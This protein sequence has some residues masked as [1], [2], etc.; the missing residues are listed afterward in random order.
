MKRDLN[1]IKHNLDLEQILQKYGY[2]FVPSKSSAKSRVYRKGEQRLSVIVDASFSAKYFTDLNDPYF[3][4]DIF[5]FLER[6]EQGNYRR[7]FEVI[8]GILRPQSA[9][10]KKELI[11]KS[12]NSAS[13]SK[14]PTVVID[15]ILREKEL[16]RI[17]RITPLTDTVYAEGRAITKEVL[18]SKEFIGRIQNVKAAVVNS[19]YLNTGFPMYDREG[20]M[21][22]IDLRNIGYKAFP[23]GERGEALWHSNYFFSTYRSLKIENGADIPTGTIGTVYQS[24]A[25]SFVFTY[26]ELGKETRVNLSSEQIGKVFYKVPVHRII[27]S[28][29]AIDAI[30]LKQLSPEWGGERRLYVATCGQPGVK[31]MAFLQDLLIQNPRA[32]LVIAQDGDSAG[33]RFAINYLALEHPCEHPEKKIIPHLTYDA[34]GYQQSEKSDVI[35]SYKISLVLRYPL[36]SGVRKA[37]SANEEFVRELIYKMK[38]INNRAVL[39]EQSLETRLDENMK[40]LNTCFSVYLSSDTKL[41][42]WVLCQLTE[43]IEKRQQ[44]KLFHCVIPTQEL[45]DFNNVLKERKGQPLFLSDSMFLLEPPLIVFQ[46]EISKVFTMLSSDFLSGGNTVNF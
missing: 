36:A 32:Q 9:L 42:A 30:S 5:T 46:S 21:V 44:Q 40:Y 20:N 28:E 16:Y 8:D 38:Q 25:E 2:E 19:K 14:R 35:G 12:I 13:V 7:I 1:F 6:M 4:G 10:E 34:S 17:Y 31:Q 11:P 45:K 26:G 39:D 3:K 33:L 27:L 24:N 18:Y 23:E 37:R 43:E 22:S 41:L 15:T 29:S